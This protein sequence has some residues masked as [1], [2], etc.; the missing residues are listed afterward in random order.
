[1]PSVLTTEEEEGA[2]LVLDDDVVDPV[3]RVGGPGEYMAAADPG[4]ED[5]IIKFSGSM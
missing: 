3:V 5:G 4:R 2:A 1:M